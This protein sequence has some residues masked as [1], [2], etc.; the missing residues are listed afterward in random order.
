MTRSARVRLAAALWIAL[1]FVVW[2]VIF[3]RVLV[4][5]GRRYS[6]EARGAFLSGQPYLRIDD[7]MRPAARHGVKVAS[8]AG[9][10]IA[11]GGLL[12]VKFAA[13]TKPA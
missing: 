13:R 1:A 10:A 4:V 3:D 11:V 6:A 2:N 7:A 12:A 8:L 5:A 9:G